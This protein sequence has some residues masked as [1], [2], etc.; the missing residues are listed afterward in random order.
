MS[1]KEE[2]VCELVERVGVSPQAM[3][4]PMTAY[5]PPPPH[6]E[7]GPNISLTFS[8]PFQQIKDGKGFWDSIRK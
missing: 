5:L 3:Q 6:S 7:S 8:K 1:V 4:G 2:T